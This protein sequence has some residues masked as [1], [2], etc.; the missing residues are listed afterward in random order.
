ML[1]REKGT[2]TV[3]KIGGKYYARW[4]I[5]GKDHYGDAR[6]TL[7]EAEQDRINNK[8][9]DGKPVIGKIKWTLSEFARQCMDQKNETFGWYGRELKDT[10]FNTNETIMTN[11]LVP[12]KLGSLKLV[13]IDALDVETWVRDLKITRWNKENGKMIAK[14]F[15]A[16]PSYKRRCHAFLSKLFT[17][18]IRNKIIKT[19]PASGVELPA[20]PKRANTHMSD[21]QLQKIYESKGRIARLLTVAADTGLRRS[22]LIKIRWSDISD[23]YLYVTNGKNHDQ[24]DRLPLSQRAAAAIGSQPRLGEWV[25]CTA[26]GKQLSK[27]NVNRDARK[28]MDSLGIPK[29]SRVHDLRGKFLNDLI[30]AGVDIQTTQAVARH[31]NART[32]LQSYLQP[33]ESSK[34]E[35]IKRLEERRGVANGGS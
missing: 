27:R 3:R 6:L 5:N 17:I 33:K 7:D 25:F 4:R 26:D 32:T 9:Q 12:S 22:E 29:D 21:Q 11:H 30:E 1:L 19:N 18:A 16:S 10:T 34:S 35:A 28:L 2:G 23:G 24:R 20:V 14:T 8:P 13:S 31:E 15:P